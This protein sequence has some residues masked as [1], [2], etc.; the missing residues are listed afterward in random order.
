MYRNNWFRAALLGLLIA[1][2]GIPSNAWSC[3]LQQQ[4]PQ[5]PPPAQQA[6]PPALPA[7]KPQQEQQPKAPPPQVT[8][9]AESQLVNI[10]ANVTDAEGNIITGLKRENFRVLDNGQPQQITNFAPTDAPI[11]I[12][13]V[14]EFSK[15]FY[16]FYSYLGKEFAYYF[17]QHLKPQDWVAF[18]TFDLKTTVQ[19]D[20]TQD[21]REIQQSIATLYFPDFTEANLFDAVIET[22]DQMAGVKGRR[23]IL[24]IASGY[25]TFSRHTLDQT[26]KRLKEADETIFCIGMAEYFQV[27]SSRTG[28]TTFLQSE[29]QM[30][31]FADLTGGYAWFPRFEGEMPSIFNSITAFLR[32]QYSIGF[33]PNTPNDGKY[34][35]L[36]VEVLDDQGNPMMVANKKGKPKPVVVYARQGYTPIKTSIVGD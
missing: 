13:I 4:G 8:I 15:L 27:R 36:K 22:V 28:G 29:N 11:T 20:F 9:T 3:L 12:A 31:T 10:D 19:V 14:M 25:D 2:L 23:S 6:P 30:R 1:V 26:Y 7:G 24:V 17:L 18:K 34:H 5:T 16:G 35:K 21:K 32:N 33:S